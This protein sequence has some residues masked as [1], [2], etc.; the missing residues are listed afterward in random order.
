MANDVIVS[1]LFGGTGN[2]LFQYA[3]GRALA[4]HHGC[5]LVLDARYGLGPRFR[6]INGGVRP[7]RTL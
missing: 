4:D 2:Q 3:A 5:K 1:R 7:S 6:L